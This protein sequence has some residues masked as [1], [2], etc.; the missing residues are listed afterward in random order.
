ME[1]CMVDHWAARGGGMR[2]RG[3]G[4]GVRE[5]ETNRLNIM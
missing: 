2:G 3:R 5:R 1:L 4:G